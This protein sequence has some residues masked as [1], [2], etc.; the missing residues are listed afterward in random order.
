M[1]SRT[2][3]KAALFAMLLSV[4]GASSHSYT[5]PKSRAAVVQIKNYALQ[6]KNA[7]KNLLTKRNTSEIKK[8]QTDLNRLQ[9]TDEG[10]KKLLADFRRH[11]AAFIAKLRGTTKFSITQKSQV[12]RYIK[13][14]FDTFGNQILATARELRRTGTAEDAELASVIEKMPPEIEAAEKQMGT[15]KK[16]LFGRM[17]MK[18]GCL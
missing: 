15:P 17:L 7:V 18:G 8:A 12:E 14:A 1:N 2:L 4:A 5:A 13:S 16:M 10:S 6:L 11:L 9:P 3:K